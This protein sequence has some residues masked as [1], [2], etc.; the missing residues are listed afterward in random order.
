MHPQ[1]GCIIM[2]GG[3]TPL[4]IAG[5]SIML[6][7]SIIMVTLGF[8]KT[9]KQVVIWQSIQIALMAIATICFGSIPGTIANGIGITR[10][11]L[12]Y[13][14]KLNRVAQ[15]IL[16]VIAT[17]STVIFNNIGWLGI[18]PWAATII[19]TLCINTQKLKFL[20]GIIGFTCILWAIHDFAMQSYVAVV[21]NIFTI[22]TCIIGMYRD[23][24]KSPKA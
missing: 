7:A 8:A 5:N 2:E 6:I 15:I 13:N 16:C 14:N 3:N 23:N 22:I 11:L 21:F 1:R 19:Y 18:F 17:L 12:S 4:I 9:K 20:K 24:D 10:N